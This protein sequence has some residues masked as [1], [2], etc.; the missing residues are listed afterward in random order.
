V[1]QWYRNRYQLH[2]NFIVIVLL[3]YDGILIHVTNADRPV[4]SGKGSNGAKVSE[5]V[6][7]AFSLTFHCLTNGTTTITVL[8]PIIESGGQL[9]LCLPFSYSFPHI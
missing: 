8:I 5:G 9:P 3:Q 2:S 1:N 7:T 6:G 4:V